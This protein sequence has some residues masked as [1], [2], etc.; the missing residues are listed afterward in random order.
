MR[1]SKPKSSEHLALRKPGIVFADLSNNQGQGTYHA[2]T[3]CE[4]H[5]FLVHKASQGQNFTDAF[6]ATRTEDTHKHGRAVGH[7]MFLDP[8]TDP[9][10]AVGEA[11]HFLEVVKGH[12]LT[13]WPNRPVGYRAD[14][15]VIDIEVP[16]AQ[17]HA[18]LS[19]IVDTLSRAYPIT[20]IVGYSGY[21]RALELHL[22]EKSKIRKWWLAAY[23][24]PVAKK[25]PNGISVWAHQYTDKGRVRGIAGP[26]D[27]S[28]IT[29]K[30]S[31]MYWTG[32]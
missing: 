2:K 22:Y 5:P 27:K 18:V 8:G 24:G 13:R 15:F 10:A 20:T 11:K 25:L 17:P 3:Y 19:A 12:V 6:H 28:I 31:A 16:I 23:P 14:F 32:K 21:S 7:Y 29:D 26:S 9:L 1:L 30:N 4:T